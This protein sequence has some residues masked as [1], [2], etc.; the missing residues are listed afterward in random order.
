[1]LQVLSFVFLL[2]GSALNLGNLNIFSNGAALKLIDFP[3]VGYVGGNIEVQ[4]NAGTS[5]FFFIQESKD[6]KFNVI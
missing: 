3:R 1:M 4:N 2:F 5:R 6:F